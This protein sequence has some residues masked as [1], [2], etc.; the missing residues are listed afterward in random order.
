MR[1]I[2]TGRLSCILL[3]FSPLNASYRGIQHSDSFSGPSWLIFKN[4]YAYKEKSVLMSIGFIAVLHPNTQLL[5]QCLYSSMRE[6]CRLKDAKKQYLS[7]EF[8]NYSASIA[9]YIDYRFCSLS[10]DSQLAIGTAN[11]V[12]ICQTFSVSSTFVSFLSA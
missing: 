9:S 7:V 12:P 2:Y 8:C 6:N 1:C 3:L 4:I 10:E 11:K 5:M